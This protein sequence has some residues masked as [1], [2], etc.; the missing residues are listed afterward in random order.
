MKKLV[1]STLMLAGV[2][3]AAGCVV[4][5]GDDTGN[6]AVTWS[7]LTADG[8][9]LGVNTPCPAGATSA[10]IYALPDGQSADPFEDRYL[11]NDRSGF[12]ADLPAGRYTVWVR[13]TDSSLVTRFAESASQSI[14]VFAGSTA[15]APPFGIF[16]DHAFYDVSWNLR[17]PGSP[18][19]VACSAVAGE[20]DVSILPTDGGGSDYETIVDCEEGLAPAITTTRPLPSGGS[21]AWTIKVALLNAQDAVIGDAPTITPQESGPLE[22]GNQYVALGVVEI[23]QNWQ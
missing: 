1:L 23:N 2:S 13:L 21:Q 8:Q 10:T 5:E 17:P 3:Q 22:Y 14:D 16:V 20:N 4:S 15:S 7:T 19:P 12:A 6:V 11:C 9:G 18:G